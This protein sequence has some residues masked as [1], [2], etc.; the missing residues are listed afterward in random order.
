MFARCRTS[1]LDGGVLHQI[2]PSIIAAL[3]VR[4]PPEEG[5][6]FRLRIDWLCTLLTTSAEGVRGVV[7]PNA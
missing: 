3:M 4:A 1:A 6:K 2:V 5:E 7:S